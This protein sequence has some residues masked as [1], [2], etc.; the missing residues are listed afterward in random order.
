[1]RLRMKAVGRVLR[2]EVRE[3]SRDRT[4][5]VNL[6]L[7]PL[8]LYPVLGF[9]A[10]Q[11]FQIIQGVAEREIST[12][13]VG[14]GVP[15]EVREALAGEERLVLEEA[16]TELVLREGVAPGKAEFRAF[17]TERAEADEPEPDA[18]LLWVPGS[19]E[20]GAVAWVIY[21]A[22]RDRSS[23]ARSLIREKLDE[24]GLADPDRALDGD[25]SEGDLVPRH[26]ARPL[27]RLPR[28]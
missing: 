12:V 23:S 17:R 14:D 18:L 15:V 6:V 9:G 5:L 16:P 28:S 24:R 11:V 2:K 8:F 27:I 19:E 26:K 3:A 21:D 4:M 25:M 10:L 7:I 1:M 13:L 22:S 20:A